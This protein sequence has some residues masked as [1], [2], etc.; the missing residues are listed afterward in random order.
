M[1]QAM[2]VV[3][4]LATLSTLY[5]YDKESCTSFL[6]SLDSPNSITQANCN[7]RFKSFKINNLPAFVLNIKQL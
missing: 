7:V 5:N 6:R 3:S 2:Q 1:G 4:K